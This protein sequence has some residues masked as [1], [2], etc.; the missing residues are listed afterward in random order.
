MVHLPQS[1]APGRGVRER[2][3]QEKRTVGKVQ[4]GRGPGDAGLAGQEKGATQVL[5]GV[6]ILVLWGAFLVWAFLKFGDRAED[7]MKLTDDDKR[8]LDGK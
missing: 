4:A 5:I 3:G 6:V 1:L 7:V 8:F 2:Q